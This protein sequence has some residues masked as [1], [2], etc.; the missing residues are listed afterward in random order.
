MCSGV[1]SGFVRVLT[2]MILCFGGCAA[3][4]PEKRT[5]LV[6]SGLL[7]SLSRILSEKIPGRGQMV[8]LGGRITRILPTEDGALFLVRAR[9]LAGEVPVSVTGRNEE[10]SPRNAFLVK[11]TPLRLPGSNRPGGPPGSNGDSPAG[12]RSATPP[13][14]PGDRVTVLG[15]VWGRGTLSRSRYRDRYL[16]VEGRYIERWEIRTNSRPMREVL[17]GEKN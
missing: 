15:E 7:E 14:N 5:V 6:S 9:P 1:Q 12:E 10:D 16:L 17:Q 4:L 8:L 13:L 11:V 3:D 2:L